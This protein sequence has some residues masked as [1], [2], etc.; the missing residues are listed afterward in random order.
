MGIHKI[1]EVQPAA[2]VSSVMTFMDSSAFNE[3]TT[4]HRFTE[5]T[6]VTSNLQRWSQF[7]S[8][9]QRFDIANPVATSTSSSS[10]VTSRDP[11]IFLKEL[12]TVKLGKFET[13][14]SHLTKILED[15]RIKEMESSMDLMELEWWQNQRNDTSGQPLLAFPSMEP[16]IIRPAEFKTWIRHRFLIPTESGGLHCDCAA[17]PQLDLYGLH[18]SC[19]CNKEGF[20]TNLHDALVLELETL[21]KYSGYWT[22]HEERHMF[23]TADADKHNRPDITINNP[24]N[25]NYGNERHQVSKVIID[26]SFTCVLDG[27][28]DGKIKAAPNRTKAMKIGTKANRRYDQKYNHYKTLIRGLT[29]Q[30][31]PPV[32]WIVPF[33]VQSSGLLH[34]A[35]LELLEKMVDSASN[36]KK[37]P[38]VNLLTYF[39]RRLSCCLAKNLATSINVRGYS[40]ISHSNSV[41]DRSLQPSMILE[42]TSWMQDE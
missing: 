1:A 31:N 29:P 35:S 21:L 4:P 9:L 28:N 20:R 23:S 33:V 32:Y 25:L 7:F 36:I 34:K 40:A 26:V 6:L 30:L 11:L 37:I 22:R 24:T 41:Q 38:G 14:Q 27:V 3:F 16:Y 2:Y 5:Q 18:L 10:T 8:C 19:G 39:K 42:G 13:L 15:K 12:R 17:K